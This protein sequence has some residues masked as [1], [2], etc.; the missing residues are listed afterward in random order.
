MED[1]GDVVRALEQQSRPLGEPE[2]GDFGGQAPGIP[3]E[4]EVA[5]A[6]VALLELL[7]P[8]PTP[9][10]ELL[11]QCQLS[12][13]L[14]SYLLLEL[15]LADRVQRHPGNRVSLLIDPDV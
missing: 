6:K 15:E 7:G 10:D 1:A 5:Q 4:D 14:G 12:P 8:R 13:A 11:R 3:S 9:V 2:I